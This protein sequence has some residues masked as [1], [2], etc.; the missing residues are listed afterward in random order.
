[1]SACI[2]D[3]AASSASA[4]LPGSSSPTADPAN[5]KSDYMKYCFYCHGKEGKGDGAIAIA[6]NPKPIDF[7][8]DVERMSR[9]DEE[10]MKSIEEGIIQDPDSR[11][12]MPAWKDV[13]SP[14]ERSNV[15]AYV[16]LLAAGKGQDIVADDVEVGQST[17]GSSEPSRSFPVPEDALLDVLEVDRQGRWMVGRPTWEA[18]V[19]NFHVWDLSAPPGADRALRAPLPP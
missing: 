2:D 10:L 6:V 16:R 8:R 19:K 17:S 12:Y 9:S 13:L 4:S 15:L 5:G 7:V 18:A 14:S 11:L 1:M 3:A